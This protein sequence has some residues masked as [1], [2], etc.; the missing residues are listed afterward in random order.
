MAV[1]RNQK[2]ALCFGA[3]Y[4]DLVFTTEEENL[5]SLVD[6][7]EWLKRQTRNMLGFACGGS[8]P[9]VDEAI[10]LY[11]FNLSERG[12]AKENC[13]IIDTYNLMLS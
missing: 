13:W 2:D 12:F 5:N 11:R 4:I 6:M 8:N 10:L 9:A 3:I 1:W 7:S